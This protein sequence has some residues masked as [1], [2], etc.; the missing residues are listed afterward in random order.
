[1]VD[2]VILE[3]N[4][5]WKESQ[6]AMLSP[7]RKAAVNIATFPQ[8]VEL[9]N[10]TIDGLEDVSRLDPE[11][12]RIAM[13]GTPGEVV[14]EATRKKLWRLIR[15]RMKPAIV[16]QAPQEN[17]RTGWLS[18]FLQMFSRSGAT[19]SIEPQCATTTPAPVPSPS[20]PAVCPDASV[21]A[22]NEATASVSPDTNFA[23]LAVAMLM[24]NTA[25]N[26]R[27]VVSE[28]QGFVPT[29]QEIVREAGGNH[30]DNQGVED[31]RPLKLSEEV[32]RKCILATSLDPLI[33]R[34]KEGAHS[35]MTESLKEMGK[36]SQRAVLGALEEHDKVIEGQLEARGAEGYK[37]L[38][39]E[40]LERLTC[41]GNLVAALGAI[42]EMKEMWNKPVV[43][44]APSRPSSTL[45]VG[46]PRMS[47]PSLRSPS[48]SIISGVSRSF[49]I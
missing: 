12:L 24:V 44:V 2:D 43:R 29:V 10:N 11:K 35:S 7:L 36:L 22:A 30:S 25:E 33:S 18:Q 23:G 46:S 27:V 38:R 13:S 37:Q 47:S 28:L 1:M 15:I 41:W 34:V 14:V 17:K 16:A 5:L 20:S 6:N 48:P 39:A 9:I 26:I 49:V 42:Q 4:A 19:N 32:V 45:L 8:L 21:A 40:T 3:L 31:Q